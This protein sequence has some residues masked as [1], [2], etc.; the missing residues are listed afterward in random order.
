MARTRRLLIIIAIAVAIF[1]V[2][3]V[4]SASHYSANRNHGDPFFFMRK[5]IVG[6]IV[7][8]VTMISVSMMP[9]RLFKKYAVW[10]ALF[11][12]LLLVIVLIPAF[13]ISAY[14]ARRWIN[15]PFIGSL[16]PGEVV[17]FTFV[18]FMAYILD[19]IRDRQK[20]LFNTAL[21]FIVFISYAAL[22]MFQPNF[23]TVM[24]LAFILALMLFIGGL[25]KRDFFVLSIPAVLTVPALIIAEPYRLRRLTA[26]LNP[27]ESPLGEGYQLIQSLYSLAG[28]GLFGVGLFNSRQK[29]LFLPFSESDFIFSII[30]EELGIFGAAML[31]AAFA[32]MIILIIKIALR[33]KDR[34]SCYLASG[35]ACIIA[36]QVLVNIAVVSGTIPPTGL[37]LPFVS[38][39]NTNLMV[40]FAGIGVA[41]RISKESEDA[42]GTFE[43]PIKKRNREGYK[44]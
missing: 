38:A 41:L 4:Y 6:V 2:V 31:M 14:G 7:G 35:I 27:W 37:P 33:A 25:R 34:F 23:S 30:V 5:Q 44:F 11:G 15:I 21:V 22:I 1:G 39:G 10:I 9:V 19:K 36:V 3:M 40:F 26:Y 13:S 24:C 16:A 42:A 32:L 20:N 43:L 17:K 29:Y 28:G 18:I 12:G 8:A